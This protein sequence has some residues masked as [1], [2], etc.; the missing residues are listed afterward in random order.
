MASTVDAIET[1]LSKE[2]EQRI[3]E[4]NRR[5]ADLLREIADLNTKQESA[6]QDRQRAVYSHQV[7]CRKAAL[8]QGDNTEKASAE[9]RKI[10]ARIN[11]LALVLQEKHADLDV[12]T[13]E[14]RDLIE[15]KRVLRVRAEE[16]RLR[17][18]LNQAEA[19][20]AAAKR[21]LDEAAARSTMAR[22]A[23]IEFHG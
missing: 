2:E 11:G 23:L 19:A 9:I 16:N 13:V 8:G 18:E 3:V 5:E 21:A 6:Q 20:H 12:N 14:L 22:R 15:K 4:L 17:I 10:E 1:E 7:E